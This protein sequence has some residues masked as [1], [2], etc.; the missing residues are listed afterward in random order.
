MTVF[1]G[2]LG[3]SYR[4]ELEVTVSSQSV[5]NNTTTIAWVLRIEQLSGSGAFSFWSDNTWSRSI[6]GVSSSGTRTYDFRTYDTLVLA[7]G[8]QV[9]THNA[10][11][12]KTI[13]VSAAWNDHGGSPLVDGSLSSSMAL[14][15]IPRASTP[16]LSASSVDAG[17][18]VTINTN[19]L[20]SAFTHTLEYSFGA[21]SGV[22]ATGVTVSQAWTPPLS[23]LNQ[24]PNATSGAVTITCK[25]YSG[26]T[27]I[28]TKNVTLTLVAGA[29]IVPDF[30]TVTNSE[31]VALIASEVGAYVQARSKLAVAITGALGAYGST[32]TAYRI[33]IA[34]QTINAASGTTLELGQSGTLALV[35]TITDSRGR[36]RSKTVNV[37]V[38]PYA[39]P[40]ID[41]ALF[42]ARRSDV[43][44]TL[45]EEGTYLR[46]DLKASVSSLINSTERNRLRYKI[47]TRERGTDPWTTVADTTLSAITYNSFVAIAGY[48]IETS[49]DVLVEV[50]DDV[51]GLV[52]IGRTLATAAVF[53]HWGDGLGIGKFWEDGALDV[54]GDGYFSGELY[55]GGERVIN[56]TD[57]ATET[58]AGVVERATTSET[59]TGTDTTRYVSPAGLAARTA[60]ASRRGLVELA[61]AAETQAGT[62]TTR[63]VTP[64]N[65]G[66]HDGIPYAIA[67]GFSTSTTGGGGSAPPVYWNGTTTVT[68]PVGRFTEPPV[69]LTDAVSGSSVLW[70]S[71]GVETSDT[72]FTYR[73]HRINATPAATAV[74]WLAIQM[75]P[76]SG[77]G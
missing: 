51:S 47:Y 29:A 68:L 75:T 31:T 63:A 59:T 18:S 45:D 2:S 70:T 3:A 53:M 40:T 66:S 35:G 38:L 33:K 15:T 61:T 52:S 26:A 24:I 7:S 46:V 62:D 74:R 34:G 8:T 6:N 37:T 39:S 56:V 58:V 48:A 11:G 14:P 73:V 42:F 36:Q 71:I 54:L 12:S 9:V 49:Y 5:E 22:I 23:L 25:T 17:T 16:T 77:D 43:G 13:A 67:A 4:L 44:G 1:T 60:T 32:I 72:S 69:I 28:G 20:S 55:S 10:D 19:R 76:T 64:E 57:L 30:T 21:A 41:G 65:I 27:L 50:L